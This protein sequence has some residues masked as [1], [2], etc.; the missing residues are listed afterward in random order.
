MKGIIKLCVTLLLLVLVSTILVK[1]Q[2]ATLKGKVVDPANRPIPEV[3]VRVL[4]HSIFTQTDEQGLFELTFPEAK[5][6]AIQFSHATHVSTQIQ[7]N[8][9]PGFSYSR[10]IKMLEISLEES[11][12]TDERDPTDINDRPQMQLLPI[13][14]EELI[15]MPSFNRSIEGVM[16]TMPGVASNNEFSS[17]YRVRGGNFDENLVYVNGIEIYRPFLTRAGQQEGLGF[18]NPDM[19]QQV[20]FST[21]GFSAE[22]GDKL[23][24]VLDITYRT[25]R[26]FRATAELGLITVNLH[27]QGRSKGKSILSESGVPTTSPGKFTYSVG[28]RRFSTAY[29]FNS[30]ETTGEYQPNF[31]DLQTMLTYT[32]KFQ[33]RAPRIRERKNG[34]MDTTYFA[35]E[36]LKF[37]SFFALT[38]N[39]F[40]FTPGGRETTFGTVQQ[41]F[42][43]R[44]GFAGQEVSAYTTG[45]GALMLTHRPNLRWRWDYIL[46]A[47]RTEESELI[48][49]EGAYLLGEV[50]TNFGSDEFNEAQFD[51]GIGSE[52]RHARNYLR[53]N[54]LSG[55]IKGQWNIQGKNKHQL[56]LG[57]KYQRQEIDDDLK[58]YLGRDSAEYLVDLNGEFDVDE[59]I[60][61][62]ARLNANLFK[63][64]AQHTWKL[65]QTKT[66]VSG[67]RIFYHDLIDQWM[68]SPRVQ[69]VQDYSQKKGGPDLRLRLAGG[70]YFQAPF[71]REFRRLDGTLNLDIKPQRAIHAIAGLDHQFQAW[72]R[73]FKLFTEAYYKRLLDLIPYEIQNIRIR[74]YPDQT[75][76]GYAYGLDMRLNGE[77]IEGVDSWLS[78]GILK[79]AEDI[80]G[81]ERGAVP[82][83]TDQRFTASLYF[84]DEF[85]LNPTFKVHMNYIFG[86]GLRFGPPRVFENRTDF[87]FPSYQRVD[88]GFSKLISFKGKDERLGRQ[89]VESIWATLEIFNLFQRENTVSHIWISDLDLRQFA[90]PNHLSARLLNARV[91]FRFR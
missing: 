10:T 17:Q 35:N 38:R 79:T 60:R 40:E 51:L 84:Q 66:L 52:L 81:D 86:S 22:Y 71:Y 62:R 9:R 74:Y 8:A 87:G 2:E 43:L 69:F 56:N 23:S 25:P 33:T 45:L 72:G 58:E 78:M 70:L 41:A 44:V 89:G 16:R 6:Y 76:D 73:P 37:T 68:F 80:Q 83:P 54:V 77:F 57:I 32:P 12:I 91:I 48:D 28:A 11:V 19:A 67:G 39:R 55:Q 31:M 29:L 85:P 1:G 24:S 64:Y 34:R 75:A 53:A 49:V 3:N 88:L 27:V 15:K 21:G 61:G 63:A 20:E 46:T 26:E 7:L 59:F 90:I 14:T 82:R 47:F 50:D 30:L 18:S 5:T 4:N 13:D 65:S 36:P 42:R